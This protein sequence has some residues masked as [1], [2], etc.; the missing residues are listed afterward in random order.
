MDAWGKWA[1]LR[2]MSLFH[3]DMKE[4]EGFYN[5]ETVHQLKC[6]WHVNVVRACLGVMNYENRGYLAHKDEQKNKVIEVIEAAIKH[7]IYV[8]V[9]RGNDQNAVIICGTPNYDQHILDA[10]H[11]PIK[12][13]K[14]IMYSLHFYASE[15]DVE[16]VRKNVQIALYNNFPLFV[17]E[18]GLTKGN[19]DGPINKE[20]TKLWWEMLDK[21]GVS[22]INWAI[23]NKPESSAALKP[24]STKWDVGK[25][26]SL[27]ES[28]WIVRNMLI[29]KHPK[30]PYGCPNW[31][32]TIKDFISKIF[33]LNDVINK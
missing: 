33:P 20:E 21:Y 12:K 1:Q 26:T 22:Y 5:D 10:F 25:I 15:G 28:G 30:A 17:T 3:S 24:G 29:Y 18:Y 4:G 6:F 32:E 11:S 7:D 31:E 14:N 19:G 13:Y 16:K 8:I 23:S 2:G 27:T 9:I